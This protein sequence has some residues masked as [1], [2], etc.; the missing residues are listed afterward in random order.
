MTR[1]LKA[2]SSS[3]E[4]PQEPKVVPREQ[5]EIWNAEQDHGQPIH[6]QTKCE[7]AP[8]F[9]I[10]GRVLARFVHFLKNGRMHHSAAAHFQPFFAAFECFRFHVNLETWLG[11]R[12]IMR[13]EAN[14]R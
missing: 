2:P 7:A 4:L 10:V 13:A 12:E 5:A 8:F 6:P 11:K 1:C 9:R 3:C 14:L